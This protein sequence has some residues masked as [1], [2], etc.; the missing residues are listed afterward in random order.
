MTEI[1]RTGEQPVGTL[2]A[3]LDE[4][5]RR[6]AVSDEEID[7]LQ[8]EAARNKRKWYREP[9]VLV[10]TFALI[11]SI[12]TFVVGQVNINSERQ[13]EDRNQLTALLA[14][15]PTALAENWE[16]PNTVASDLVQLVAGSAAEL[17][18]K[19][20]PEDSTAIEKMVVAGALIEGNNMLLA[21]RLATAAEQ[22]SPRGT[23][24][25]AAAVVIGR[26]SFL[27][28]DFVGGRAAYRRAISLIQLPE[29]ELD[30]PIAR[31]FQKFNILW[32]WVSD[33]LSFSKS[34]H[35]ATERLLEMNET[36]NRLPSD[37][38]GPQKTSL[39]AHTK[40][41]TAVCP[42]ASR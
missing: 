6:V 16:R 35:D 4:V 20:P 18:G 17:I 37:R 10:A 22:Q 13:I 39:D 23:E 40:M 11:I 33:E 41:V 19:L 15:L 12:F 34:C 5:R 28:A 9:S 36:L 32:Y 1:A 29:A 31:D 8:V 3:E 2:R 42:I 30:S 7:L 38:I 26:I 25:A 24:K 14:Q 21:Q 27:T